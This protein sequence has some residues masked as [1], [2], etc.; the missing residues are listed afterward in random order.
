MAKNRSMEAKHAKARKYA[1]LEGKFHQACEIMIDNIERRN[2]VKSASEVRN[3]QLKNV[4]DN[5]A[6]IATK[7]KYPNYVKGQV[8]CNM[9]MNKREPLHFSDASRY[10]CKIRDDAYT[11]LKNGMSEEF[12]MRVVAA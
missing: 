7:K 12:I 5:V 9:P 10:F 8:E 2:H 3:E 11:L 6:M 1:M 4:A